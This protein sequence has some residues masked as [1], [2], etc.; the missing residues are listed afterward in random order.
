MRRFKIK[1]VILLILIGFIVGII[2]VGHSDWNREYQFKRGLEQLK[3]VDDIGYDSDLEAAKEIISMPRPLSIKILNRSIN[4][5]PQHPAYLEVVEM[6]GKK[7]E[8]GVE[9]FTD[10]LPWTPFEIWTITTVQRAK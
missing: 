9:C 7:Y 8:I 6:N 2:L 1:W 10:P 3:S 5:K 4:T